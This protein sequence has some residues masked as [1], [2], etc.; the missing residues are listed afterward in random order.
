LRFRKHC[1]FIIFMSESTLLPA[2][3]ALAA[4]RTPQAIALTSGAT[5][6]NYGDLNAV[7][8]QFAAGLM[9][10][11]LERG[12]RVAIYLDKRFETVV[13]SFGAPAAGAVFVP[14]NPLLKPE[15]VA[16]ILRDCNVRVLVTSPERFT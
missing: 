3:I 1:C 4:E 2:L 13:A 16:F 15:Q 12:E 14:V 10:L 5:S 9:G 6:W 7:V 11:G 8:R